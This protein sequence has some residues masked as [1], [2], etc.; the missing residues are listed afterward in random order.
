MSRALVVADSD[1]HTEEGHITEDLEMRKKMVEKRLKKAD[2]LKKQ[3]I[4]P[5]LRGGEGADLLLLSWG[6]TKGASEEAAEK[7]R[8]DGHSA[9]TLHFSQVWPLLPEQFLHTL[10]AAGRVVAVEGNATGQLA[11]LIRGETGF[12]IRE[13]VLRYDGLPLTAD[14]ILGALLGE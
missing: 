8:T 11:R 2:D 14:Y 13:K 7:L 1:E 4:P 6:S 9:A 5:L 3:T 12:E 10:Q